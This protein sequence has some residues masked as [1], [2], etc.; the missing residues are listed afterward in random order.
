MKKKE[1]LTKKEYQKIGTRKLKYK[2]VIHLINHNL[3]GVHGK[4]VI[5]VLECSLVEDIF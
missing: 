4:K 5:V 1:S 3:S 2:W